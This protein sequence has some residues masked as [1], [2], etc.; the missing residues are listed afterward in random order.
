MDGIL[1]GQED[2]SRAYIDD[3]LVY[4]KTWKEHLVH[5]ATVLETLRKAGAM[6]KPSKCQWGA[7]KLQYLGHVIGEGTVE[8]PEARV[9]FKKPK[10]KKDVRAFLESVGYYR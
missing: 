1:E 10:T 9:F 8:V 4:S 7:S 2:H 5:I 3:I 6:V